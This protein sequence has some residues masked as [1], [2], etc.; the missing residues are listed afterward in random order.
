MV[1]GDEMQFATHCPYCGDTLGE[2]RA[3]V[4]G[5]DGMRVEIC[6]DCKALMDAG[7]DP[8]A[9]VIE[10]ETGCVVLPHPSPPSPPPPY[11]IADEV[12]MWLRENTAKGDESEQ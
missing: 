9:E 5:P 8:T 6:L 1:Y 12:E 3:V 11:G 2:A 4:K 7:G 10:P